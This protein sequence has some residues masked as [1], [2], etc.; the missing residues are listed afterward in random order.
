MRVVSANL[1]VDN[2]EPSGRLKAESLVVTRI[3]EHRHKWPALS[4]SPTD[5]F[6]NQDSADP[7]ALMAGCDAQGRDRDHL[8][9]IE[10]SARTEYVADHRVVVQGNELQTVDACIQ[11]QVLSTMQT[12][13][14]PSRPGLLN[15]SRTILMMAGRS[16]GAG[17]LIVVL[18]RPLSLT[19]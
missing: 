13:S 2:A 9:I 7:L 16:S 18:R 6:L 4:V 8:V 15:A 12:S 19:R 1:R 11:P 10:V 14:R 17:G 5:Q 3:A